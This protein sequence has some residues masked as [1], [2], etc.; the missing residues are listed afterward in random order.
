[1]AY[2]TDHDR[3]VARFKSR[4]GRTLKRNQIID[5]IQKAYPNSLRFGTG[6]SLPCGV[7]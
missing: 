3:F 2:G 7:D 5:I 4:S 6:I 1:M